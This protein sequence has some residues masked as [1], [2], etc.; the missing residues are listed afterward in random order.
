MDGL[1][2]YSSPFLAK[3]QQ[4]VPRKCKIILP[5][6]IHEKKKKCIFLEFHLHHKSFNQEEKMDNLIIQV[7]QPL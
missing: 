7:I 5:E 1:N 3:R 4:G 6:L 2:C